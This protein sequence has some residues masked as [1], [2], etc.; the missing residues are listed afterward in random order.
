MQMDYDVYYSKNAKLR[1]KGAW[2]RSR[3]LLFNS[4][5]PQYFENGESYKLLKVVNRMTEIIGQSLHRGP[6]A[7]HIVEGGGEGASGGFAPRN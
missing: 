3:N 5:I 1:G 4:E 6:V 7:E 2:P